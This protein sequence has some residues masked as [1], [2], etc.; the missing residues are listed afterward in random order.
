MGFADAAN[1]WANMRL[2]IEKIVL[3]QVKIKE[4]VSVL[5]KDVSRSNE[6]LD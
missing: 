1:D 2:D 3:Q 5:K 4:D 6:E